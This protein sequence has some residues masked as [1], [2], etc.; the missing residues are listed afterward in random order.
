MSEHMPTPWHGVVDPEGKWGIY[1]TMGRFLAIVDNKANAEFI[2][3]A[4]NAHDAQ[5]QLIGELVEALQE[6]V[7][8]MESLMLEYHE[9]GESERPFIVMCKSWLTEARTALAHARKP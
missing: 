6:G 3:Q 7:Q 9:A 1:P 2:V 8:R 5:A 4:V